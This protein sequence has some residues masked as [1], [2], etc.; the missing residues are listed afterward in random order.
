MLSCGVYC[1][2]SILSRFEHDNPHHLTEFNRLH[3]YKPCSNHNIDPHH[4]HLTSRRMGDQTLS[5]IKYKTN[6]RALLT[7]ESHT[8][9]KSHHELKICQSISLLT[10]DVQTKTYPASHKLSLNQDKNT[11][12]CGEHEQLI[13]MP[14]FNMCSILQS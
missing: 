14:S 5:T 11:Y 8:S 12:I 1:H 10:K 4:G 13:E 9:S 6:E 2:D 3:H 7:Q